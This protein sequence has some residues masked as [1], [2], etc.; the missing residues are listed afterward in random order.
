[1]KHTP[2]HS[3]L[4]LKF[5]Q[6]DGSHLRKYRIQFLPLRLGNTASGLAYRYQKKEGSQSVDAEGLAIR[7]KGD[8]WVFPVRYYPEIRL[9]HSKPAYRHGKI[10]ADCQITYDVQDKDGSVRPGVDWRITRYFSA[11]G[12]ARICNDSDR[13]YIGIRLKLTARSHESQNTQ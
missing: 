3:D 10:Y 9:F 6:R 2:S 13:N 5:E 11:G 7:A 4:K 12:E 1:V 8:R